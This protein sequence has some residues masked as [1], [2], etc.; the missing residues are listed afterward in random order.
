MAHD[1]SGGVKADPIAMPAISTANDCARRVSGIQL[2]M[3]R[4]ATGNAA[5]WPM[6]SAKRTTI[7]T[8]SDARPA[9][10]TQP[11]KRPVSA[12]VMAHSAAAQVNVRP[13]PSRSPDT[14]HGT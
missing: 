5:A 7:S 3:A 1:T 6:P 4:D 13:G 14:P 11:G 2:T 9:G 8:A 10:A 12:V